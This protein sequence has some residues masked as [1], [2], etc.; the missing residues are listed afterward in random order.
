MPDPRRGV[1]TVSE[2]AEK[3]RTL[4]VI[5]RRTRPVVR[6]GRRPQT[7]PGVDAGARCKSTT[8]ELGNTIVESANRQDVQV[9]APHVRYAGSVTEERQ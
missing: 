8:D 2:F 1:L 9:R 5:S 6:E 4:G 7:D 3:V